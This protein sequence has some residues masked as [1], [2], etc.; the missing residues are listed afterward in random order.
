ME[1]HEL[2]NA[3][4]SDTGI[5]ISDEDCYVME[6]GPQESALNEQEVQLVDILKGLI[7]QAPPGQVKAITDRKDHVKLILL[8]FLCSL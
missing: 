2:E 5:I 1:A 7:A 6:P 8:S 3:Q 4:E